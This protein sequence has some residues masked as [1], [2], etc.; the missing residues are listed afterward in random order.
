MAYSGRLIARIEWPYLNVAFFI[1]QISFWP[2]PRP[3]RCRT[4]PATDIDGPTP[5][6][7]TRTPCDRVFWACSKHSITFWPTAS[8]DDSYFLKR[9]WKPSS[10]ATTDVS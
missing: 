5:R 8:S 2:M 1:Q 7:T 3:E 4:D 10:T 9:V 6:R